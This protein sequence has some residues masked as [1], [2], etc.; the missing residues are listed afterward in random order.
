[1]KKIKTDKDSAWGGIPA[2]TSCDPGSLEGLLES[3]WGDPRSQLVLLPSQ[4]KGGI[5]RFSPLS[6]SVSS[7]FPD[8]LPGWVM[9]L[10]MVDLL[11]VSQK[12]PDECQPRE[13]TIPCCMARLDWEHQEWD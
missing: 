6:A 12:I 9:L 11:L 10:A 5:W 13:I 4:K 3:R 7:R 8:I 1:M 2:P